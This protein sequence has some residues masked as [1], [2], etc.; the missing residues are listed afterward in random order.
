MTAA[1]ESEARKT[2]RK[3]GPKTGPKTTKD[4]APECGALR[5]ELD[6]ADLLGFVAL[7]TLSDLELDVVAFVE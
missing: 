3:T 4:P 7:P 6:L 5:S 1:R 2:G